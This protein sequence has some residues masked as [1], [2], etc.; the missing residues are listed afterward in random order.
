M[1]KALLNVLNVEPLSESENEF[2]NHNYD[3]LH[4][5]LIISDINLKNNF[6]SPY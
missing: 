2:M 3:L 4:L 6:I 1:A 5:L